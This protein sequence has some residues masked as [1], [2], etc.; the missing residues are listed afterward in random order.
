MTKLKYEVTKD[1]TFKDWE[2]YLKFGFRICEV[3]FLEKLTCYFPP[4]V[5]EA[6]TSTI[7]EF[8][9]IPN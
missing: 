7:S 2:F 5:H 6:F 8:P 3:S 4:I 1:W 9:M